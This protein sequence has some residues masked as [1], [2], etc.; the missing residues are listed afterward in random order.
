VD[1]NK[2]AG[3]DCP[4]PIIVAAA[5]GASRAGFFSASVL[6]YLLQEAQYHDIDPNDVR[7]RLFA[8]S[9][10]SGSSVGALM[11][12][13]ALATKRNSADHACPQTSFALWWGQA[14]NNWRDCFEAL[15]SGDFL[16]PVF[17]GLTFHDIVRFGW[18]RDRAAILEE[19]WERRYDRL[20][21]QPD[22]PP[23]GGC[24]GLGCPFLTLRP[25][26][27]RWIPL[28]VL[29]GTSESEGNRIVTTV[30]APTYTARSGPCPTSHRS[31]PGSD[32]AL[33]AHTRDFH[34][35]LL[36]DPTPPEG[37]LANMQRFFLSDFRK[38]RELLDVRLST[39][40]HNSARFPIISPPGSVRNRAHQIIDR[41]V[42]GGYIENYGALSAL[43]IA[44]AMRAVDSGLAPFV[45]VISNDPDDPLDPDDDVVSANP[46]AAQR[47]QE[48]SQEQK[49]RVDVDDGEVLT[50]LTA[51]I[52]TLANT[53]TARG[54]HAVIQ[55]RSALFTRMP[56]CRAHVAHVRVWPQSQETSKRSRAVSMSWWLSAPIQRHLHQQTE[57]TKN[58]NGNGEILKLVWEMLAA[59][60]DCA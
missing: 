52:T 24:R 31:G 13:S 10:V 32:C 60:S 28:L 1:E 29:N 8:I 40:A 43:E 27:G 2:C 33:L 37:W 21:T 14:I 39:A 20:I 23:T 50:E 56:N 30:L 26:K 9:G 16:T 5:G 47:Y 41:I 55:L 12:V 11:A 49:K 6:G 17:I 51:P 46:A 38:R 44:L 25:S 45:L 35:D 34:S 19:A 58:E 4:R 59:K 36:N 15:T 18:W 3:A 7:K 53:R 54:T 42:D 48:K 57:D 22:D